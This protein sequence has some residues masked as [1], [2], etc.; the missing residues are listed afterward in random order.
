MSVRS[1]NDAEPVASR[2]GERERHGDRPR[3]VAVH[4]ADEPARARAARDDD[5]LAGSAVEAAGLVPR[6]GHGLQEVEAGR[7]VPVD[8]GRVAEHRELALVDDELGQLAGPRAHHERHRVARDERLL[9]ALVEAAGREVHRPGQHPREGERHLVGRRDPRAPLVVL[10]AHHALAGEQVRVGA[11]DAG[12]LVG[13]VEV[14]REVVLGGLLRAS[15][16]RSSP[17][18]GR[19][20][21]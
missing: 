3:G 21:P 11:L 13:A 20:C 7:R 15:A 18:P 16:C 5:E 2:A 6:G 14:D 10:V 12:G 4:R 8:V 17:S 19:R 9:V 1:A